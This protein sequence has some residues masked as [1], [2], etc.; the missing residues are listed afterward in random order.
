MAKSSGSISNTKKVAN[1]FA[2]TL[3]KGDVVFLYGSLGAGKTTFT[4][5]VLKY[6]GYQETVQSPTFVLERI[7]KINDLCVYH[8]DLYRIKK[9]DL[10]LLEFLNEKDKNGIYLIEWP[11]LVEDI[12]QPNY[13]VYLKLVSEK[14]RSIEVLAV[15]TICKN[16]YNLYFDFGN[17]DKK[18][19]ILKNSEKKVDE[20]SFSDDNSIGAVDKILKRNNLNID[21][22]ESADFKQD[23]DSFTGA[24]LSSAIV[25]VINLAR[26]NIKEYSDIKLPKYSSSPHL[27]FSPKNT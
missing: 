9:K 15:Y 6:F 25:N 23:S 3:N 4:K 8:L 21:D 22:I 20:I 17:K 13:K 12:I 16:M 27:T 18:I 11:E 24:R 19:I 26:G 2:S 14:L 5:Y 1:K 7:Y 10:H